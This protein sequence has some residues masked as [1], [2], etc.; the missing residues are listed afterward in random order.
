MIETTN[1]TLVGSFFSLSHLWFLKKNQ[2]PQATSF[3]WRSAAKAADFACLGIT[4]FCHLEKAPIHGARAEKHPIK[5]DKI[6]V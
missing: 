1:Q 2:S 5:N 6:I 3:L 4:R